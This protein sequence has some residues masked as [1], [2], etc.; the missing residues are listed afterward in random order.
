VNGLASALRPKRISDWLV[1]LDAQLWLRAAAA[2]LAFVLIGVAA[3]W[4]ANEIQVRGDWPAYTDMDLYL[5]AA[6]ELSHGRNP[7]DAPD[8]G[9]H[10]YPYPPLFA[11]LIAVF[12]AV[13][14]ASAGYV[15]IVTTALFLLV[16]VWLMSRR[17][18]FAAPA[19]LALL[20][21]GLL[22]IGRTARADLMHGQLNFM[23]LLLLL[24]GLMAWRARRMWA[25]G[26]F[27]AVAICCKPFLGVVVFFLVR[28]KSWK[29]ALA[30]VAFS[31]ILFWSSF[32]PTYPNVFD[33]FESWRE[34]TRH[35]ASIEYAANPLN[36]SFYALGLRLFTSNDYSEAWLIATPLA[37]ALLALAAVVAIATFWIIAAP[38]RAAAPDEAGAFD[39]LRFGA[40]LAALLS[41]GP[42]TE[43]DHMFMVLPGVVGAMAL[44]WRRIRADSPRQGL[45]IAMATAWLVLALVLAW[46]R[47][48]LLYFGDE[49]T[50]VHLRGAG[51]LLSGAYGV[52][53]LTAAVF[54]AIVIRREFAVTRPGRPAAA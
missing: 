52:L 28:Q 12:A 49:S 22:L 17:F 40:A 45:W 16:S 5:D 54:T 32:L 42:V 7:Y 43:G 36:Q 3:V 31:A 29:A 39:L 37:L 4:V 48:L 27:W 2:L 23:L 46:P 20:G 50:W 47:Q 26:A 8:Q 18:G 35:Y 10:R 51:I 44:T 41:I 11:E 53:L 15:W 13:F 19:H 6:R 9:L 30:T 24:L 25:A 34:T 33:T 14:G 38:G 1:A 21:A